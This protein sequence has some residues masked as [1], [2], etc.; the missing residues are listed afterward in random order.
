[1]G[2]QAEVRESHEQFSEAWSL[3]AR[4]SSD[5]EVVDPYGSR[6]VKARHPWFLLNAALLAEPVSCR[7]KLA[8]WAHAAIEWLRSEHRPWFLAGSQRWQGDGTP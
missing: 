1:M 3:Y 6:V 7:G 2:N 4:Y 8:S 5:G